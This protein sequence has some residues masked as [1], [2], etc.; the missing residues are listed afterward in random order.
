[1]RVW[2]YAQAFVEQNF[3]VGTLAPCNKENKVV[4]RS[5][6]RNVRHSVS[7]LP[8]NG[9]ET[10]ELGVL[11][12]MFLY[13]LDDAMKLVQALRCLRIKIYIAVEIELLHIFKLLYHNGVA[14]CLP[15]QA[16]HF[17]VSQLAKDNN[18][19]CGSFLPIFQLRFQVYLFKVARNTVAVL[20]VLIL[21]ATPTPQG[22]WRL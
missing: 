8:T 16:Q 1:M 6:Q 13:I 15:H 2:I 18:L 10:A 17:G 5:K 7:Y 9:I 19:R 12:D 20:F 4:L 21:Y 11:G 14:M 3:S 22:K